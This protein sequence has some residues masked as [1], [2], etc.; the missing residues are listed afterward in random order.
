MIFGSMNK[1]LVNSF[2]IFCFF[3]YR[4]LLMLR[5]IF[6]RDL[7]LD[8]EF[9]LMIWFVKIMILMVLRLDWFRRILIFSIRCR[10]WMLLMLVLLKLNFNF[11]FKL[12]IW[13]EIWMMRVGYEWVLLFFV[14]FFKIIS[15]VNLLYF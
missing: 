9:R 13:R 8:W 7:F 15:M 1:V 3:L 6:W 5:L 10:N 11:K 14:F 12:M 4:F 2:K